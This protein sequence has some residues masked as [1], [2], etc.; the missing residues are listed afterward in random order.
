MKNQLFFVVFLL[1]MCSCNDQQAS[2]KQKSSPVPVVENNE[3]FELTLYPEMNKHS[4]ILCGKYK[5]HR[6]HTAWKGQTVEC[7]TGVHKFKLVSIARQKDF[8]S[9]QKE[10]EKHGRI[11][12]VQ[13]IEA[14]KSRFPISDGLGWVIVADPAFYTEVWSGHGTSYLFLSGYKGKQWDG[15]FEWCKT[16]N[17]EDWRWLVMVE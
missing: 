11:P 12:C 14:F 4:E 3:I 17:R 15:H 13:W 16:K 10:L 6:V 7:V 1:F 2:H 5:A 8:D 9:V